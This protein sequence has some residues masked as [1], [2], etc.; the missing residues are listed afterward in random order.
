[1]DYFPANAFPLLK[2]SGEE[3]W[4][5]QKVIIRQDAI[6]EI[7]GYSGIA[8]DSTK[9][10]EIEFANNFQNEKIQKYNSTIKKTSST[11]YS[12]S[13]NLNTSLKQI[14]ESA[15]RVTLCNRVSYWT[16]CGNEVKCEIL[17]SLDNKAISKNYFQNF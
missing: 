13:K 10:K 3:L 4:I 17:Y 9:F 12:I 8:R 16:Y 2:K 6:G 5:S 14:I 1:V 15:A 7:V 11:N